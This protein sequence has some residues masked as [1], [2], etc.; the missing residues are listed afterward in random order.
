LNEQFKKHL[1]VRIEKQILPK[2]LIEQLFVLKISNFLFS[3]SPH[4]LSPKHQPQTPHLVKIFLTLQ[5]FSAELH[6]T[7]FHPKAEYCFFSLTFKL[8]KLFQIF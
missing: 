7:F 8:P 1:K 4:E 5:Q 3:N 2:S 6:S